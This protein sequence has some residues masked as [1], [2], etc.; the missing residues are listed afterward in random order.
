MRR[1]LLLPLLLTA[2]AGCRSLDLLD[3]EPPPWPP[4]EA[5]E[6][7]DML[8]V[9]LTGP[10]WYGG[11]PSV[12]DL[13]IAQRRGVRLVIDA[14]APGGGPE[15]DLLGKCARAGLDLVVLG[16]GEQGLTDEQVDR[17]LGL[18]D[19]A[20]DGE[21]LLF[22]ENGDRSATLVAIYRAVKVGVPVDVAVREARR[23]GMKPGGPE[24]FV[25]LQV[26]RLRPDL[27][28]KRARGDVT[29]G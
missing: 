9:Y 15:Y 25:R 29:A 21:V 19:G 20:G 27:A 4:I 11:M 1:A 26:D 14:T 24:R 18:L 3:R 7:G 8:N 23:A 17:F 22:C 2:L 16:V 6:L 10:V 5:C 28:A 12:A 13:D